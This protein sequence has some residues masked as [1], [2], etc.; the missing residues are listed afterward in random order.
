[1]PHSKYSNQRIAKI[2]TKD[3]FKMIR[4]AVILIILIFSANVAFAVIIESEGTA[5]IKEGNIKEA[6]RLALQNALINGLNKYYADS[7]KQDIPEVTPEFFKFINYYRI[8]NRGVE[9]FTVKYNVQ[10]KLDEVAIDDLKYFLNNFVHSAIYYIDFQGKTPSFIKEERQGI[11]DLS[12]NIVN[13]FNEYN[14]TTKY[15]QDLD[16]QLPEEAD[17]QDVITLF[18]SSRAKYL[19]YFTIEAEMNSLDSNVL[20]RVILLTNIYKKD[21]KFREIKS[22]ASAIRG[23]NEES[24]IEAFRK[25]MTN[26]LKYVRQNLIELPESNIPTKNIQLITKNFGSVGNIQN[27]MNDLKDKNI[28]LDFKVLRYARNDMQMEILTKFSKDDLTDKLNTY[29]EKYKFS[30][31]SSGDHIILNFDGTNKI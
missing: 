25:S 9:N 7:G 18:G 15:Q 11:S 21:S 16:M 1:M 8:L 19:F 30:T 10:V 22:V 23:T 31:D 4:V 14:F 20:S 12:K 13:I 27:L 26:T 5:V 29:A 28:I 3:V 17:F 24:F 2:K 6:D